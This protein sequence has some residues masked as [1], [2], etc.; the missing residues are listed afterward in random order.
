MWTEEEYLA[1]ET[2]HLV[3]L[4]DGNIEVLPMPTVMHQLMVLYLYKLLDSF[5]ESKQLGRVLAAPLKVHLRK[6]KFREPDVLFLKRGKIARM[7]NQFW[8]TADLV[9]EVVSD[10]NRQHDLKK[11]RRDYA[12][13]GIPEYWIVDPQ[14][15]TITVLTLGPSKKRKSY[16]V[17]GVFASGSRVRSKLLAGFEVDVEAVFSQKP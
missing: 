5:V 16:A 7:G 8:D 10:D 2:N 14:E 3:E 11:K 15:S 6:D 17:H 9:M 1:L 4:S 12:T 13:A